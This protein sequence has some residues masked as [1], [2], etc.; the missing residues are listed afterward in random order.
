MERIMYIE[1][2]SGGLSGEARIGKVK[3]SKTKKSIHYNG[4]TFHS[5]N[6][7]GYKSNYYDSETKE[8]YWIS[9]CKKDGTDRLYEERW[10]IYID[11]DIQ[12]EY[13]TDIRKLPEKVGT[14]VINSK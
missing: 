1:N 8:E 9:G 3:F 14:I 11:A 5:L 4:Q 2:K 7:A 10:P 12:E 6:G 13:W